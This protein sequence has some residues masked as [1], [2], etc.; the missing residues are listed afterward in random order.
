MDKV[1]LVFPSVQAMWQFKLITKANYIE[2]NIPALSLTCS[3]SEAEIDLA[4]K[5][6]NARV[7]RLK[8]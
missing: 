6:Y 7:I 1:T 3:C 8:G 2:I 4:T 5:K